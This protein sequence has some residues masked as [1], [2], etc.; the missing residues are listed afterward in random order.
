VTDDILEPEFLMA[1][2]TCA[3]VLFLCC[4]FVS[5]QIHAYVTSCLFVHMFFIVLPSST[6]ACTGMF[7]LN[8]CF[9][10]LYF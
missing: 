1:S 4:F 3:D 2:V 9:F 10:Y 5:G 8:W 7:T 6:G